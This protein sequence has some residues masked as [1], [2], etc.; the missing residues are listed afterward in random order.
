MEE[1][2]TL[3][4]VHWVVYTGNEGE[5]KVIKELREIAFSI[6]HSSKVMGSIIITL[7]LQEDSV[8]NLQQYHYV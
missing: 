1:P 6:L 2:G 5:I 3:Q 8:K 4:S 7:L